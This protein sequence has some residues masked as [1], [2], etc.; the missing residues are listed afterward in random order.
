MTFIKGQSGNPN[1]KPKGAI[2]KETSR[3]K[4]ALNNLLEQSSDNMIAW[5]EEI[6]NPQARFGVLK[7]FAEY[8]HPKLARTEIQPLDDEGNKTSWNV[9]ITHVSPKNDSSN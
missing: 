1:G 9:S 3:F 6:D 4:E 5:L 8:I 2:R 7:D